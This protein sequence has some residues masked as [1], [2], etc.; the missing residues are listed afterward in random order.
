MEGEEKKKDKDSTKGFAG[1]TS[2]VSD[3]VSE[4]DRTAQH[5][6]PSTRATA[7]PV[8]QSRTGATRDGDD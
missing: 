4:S 1:L 8:E 5:A 7:P 2:M 3:V 6:Q